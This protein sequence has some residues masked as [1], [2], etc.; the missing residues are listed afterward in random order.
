MQEHVEITPDDIPL[1]CTLTAGER[2]IREAE[3][4][5]IFKSC[6]EVRE[7]ADGYAFRYAGEN[8]WAE[9]LFHLV[10]EERDCCPFF[11]FELFFAPAKGSIELCIRGQAEVKEIVREQFLPLR[12]L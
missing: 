4:G 6:L 7:L 8:I 12:E 5:N 1:A 11:T 3:I 2:R 10:M 9:K